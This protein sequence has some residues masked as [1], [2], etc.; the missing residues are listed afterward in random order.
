MDWRDADDLRRA[1]GAE[2][3]DYLKAGARALPRNGPFQTL[4]ELLL[5]QGMTAAI[6][7]SVRPYLTLAGSGQVNLNLAD[8][9]VLLALPGITEE[10]VAVLL[11][12]RRQQRTLGNVTDLERE[13]SPGARGALEGDLATL[14]AQTTTET[15]EVEVR[16]YGWIPGSPV[17]ARVTGVMV[18]ARS[19][20]F[21]VWSRTE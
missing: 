21:Y 12:Y 11:R 10:A 5:V 19:A 1:R 7:D 16:S 14:L 3:D 13:L 9:P 4:P 15:R 17:R 20:V 2:R 8:R 6:Y 18:R